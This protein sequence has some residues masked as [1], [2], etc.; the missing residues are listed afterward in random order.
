[1]TG[2]PT[3]NHDLGHSFIYIL[4]TR[5]VSSRCN[6]VRA[7]Q[8]PQ[9]RAP[10][11]A[12]TPGRVSATPP[13]AQPAAPSKGRLKKP[14]AKIIE[15]QQSLRKRTATTAPRPTQDELLLFP[16]ASI[17]VSPERERINTSLKKIAVLITNLKETII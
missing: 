16:T 9:R 4:V 15:A 6:A 8:N 12:S 5:L 17:S 10:I 2:K 1:M 14:S 7:A 13:P 3:K 11:A